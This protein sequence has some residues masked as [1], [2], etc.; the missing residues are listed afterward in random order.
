MRP[1]AISRSSVIRAISRRTPS[2][3]ESITADG[4]L[5]D[6]QV[7]S[8]QR[9]ERA[10]VAAV[11]A[12]DPPLHLVAGQLDQPGRRLG[13][14]DGGQALHGG[15]EDAARPPL[16]LA[17]GLLL[18]LPQRQ[19]GLVPRLLLD[20]GD[21]ELLGLGGAQARRSARAHGAAPAWPASAPRSRGRGCARGPPAPGCGARGRRAGPPATRCREAPAPPSARSPR[22]GPA[23]RRRRRG[24]RSAGRPVPGALRLPRRR[25]ARASMERVW[26]SLPL[27]R[28]PGR[29]AASRLQ[30]F[31]WRSQRPVRSPEN[32]MSDVAIRQAAAARAGRGLAEAGS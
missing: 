29:V 5:V 26:P 16:G 1:S 4:R 9:L 20:L 6:D 27:L 14:V 22:G 8:G 18:D 11:P 24:A 17:L 21:Q 25:A 31:A 28:P 32:A 19:A 7:D 13:G 3:L 30:R 23:A 2:K 10:D 12:D 15:R